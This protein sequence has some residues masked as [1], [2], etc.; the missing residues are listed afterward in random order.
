MKIT[1]ITLDFAQL[2]FFSVA[3]IFGMFGL[4]SW[5][6]VILLFLSSIHIKFD[7]TF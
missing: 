7:V 2:V 5:W 4:V 6:V 3:V 1:G